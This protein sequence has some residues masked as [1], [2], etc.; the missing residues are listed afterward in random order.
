M[1]LTSKAVYSIKLCCLMAQI[2]LSLGNMA[3][4]IFGPMFVPR[5]L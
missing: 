1:F 3:D 5:Y 2:R 4:T